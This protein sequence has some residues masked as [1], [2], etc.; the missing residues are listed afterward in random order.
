MT[1]PPTTSRP[2]DPG[3][4]VILA[5]PFDTG[6]EVDHASLVRQVDHAFAAG[7][8][9][10]VALGVFGEAA[11]LSLPEQQQVAATVARAAAGERVVLGVSGRSTAVVVEQGTAVLRAAAGAGADPGD[12]ALM[13][14]VTT[15]DEDALVGHLDEVHRRTGAGIVVQDYPSPAGSPFP[16]R[17]WSAWCDAARTSSPSRRRRRRPHRRSRNWSPAPRYRSSAASAGVGLV[18]ELPAGRPAR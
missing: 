9:G 10:V 11:S 1:S 17:P 6:G 16:R 14:Q 5:T 2:L 12:L 13:V 3:L 15:P 4:W 7:A 18:D 8:V